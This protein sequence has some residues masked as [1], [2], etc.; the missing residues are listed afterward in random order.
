MHDHPVTAKFELRM[1]GG[2]ALLRRASRALCQPLTW[3]QGCDVLKFLC[4]GN[5]VKTS[6]EARYHFVGP[7]PVDH[8]GIPT[9]GANQQVSV[10]L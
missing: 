6:G 2:G 10:S 5:R 8:D 3:E 9:V 1:Y 4:G 7:E